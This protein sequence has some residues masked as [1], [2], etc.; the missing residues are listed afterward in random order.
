MNNEAQRQA[1][2]QESEKNEL[3][4]KVIGFFL[5]I[6]IILGIYGSFLYLTY[7]PPTEEEIR[8]AAEEE[9]AKWLFRFRRFGDYTEV[10]R[11]KP[12]I[13]F[14]DTVIGQKVISVR[15]EQNEYN[16]ILG[17]DEISYG[18]FM[19]SWESLNNRYEKYKKSK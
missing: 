1:F 3:R 7:V 17:G 14:G 19:D 9:A 13:K 12:I 6:F 18:I 11:I 16:S 2:E 15:P 8:I 10:T 4:V 5:S